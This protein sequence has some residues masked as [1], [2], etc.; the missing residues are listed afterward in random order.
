MNK[1]NLR[2][3]ESVRGH[4]KEFVPCAQREP[5]SR[6]DVRALLF[7]LG[8]E[9]AAAGTL[10]A[11]ARGTGACKRSESFRR[12]AVRTAHTAQLHGSST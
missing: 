9:L 11:L 3:A 6:H 1:E 10:A 12:C 7:Y 2:L 4:L 5:A 8:N